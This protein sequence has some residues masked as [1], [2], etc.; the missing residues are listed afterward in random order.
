MRVPGSRA[1]F[2]TILILGPTVVPAVP[3]EAIELQLLASGLERPLGLV[4]AGDNTNRMFLVQQIGL[5]SII[6][7]GE[8]DPRPFLDISRQVSCCG[9]RGL[10]GLAFHPGY[11]SNGFFFAYYIDEEGDSVVSRFEVSGRSPD[12]ARAASEVEFLRFEQPTSGHKG[13]DI[14]FGS[15]GFLYIASGD[16]SDG[17]DPED[18]AQDLSSPL[19]KILRLDVD[20]GPGAVPSANPFVGDPQARDDIWALG[21]RNPWRIS[22]DRETG[23]FFVADVGQGRR[24]EVNFQSADSTGGEN[25]GWRRVEGSLCYEPPTGC[26]QDAFTPPVLEYGHDV[27]CAVTGGYRYRGKRAPTLR[28]EYVFGDYCAGTIWSAKPNRDGVWTSRILA[29]TGRPIVTF[30][31]DE[32]GELYLV[33]F[34]GEVN[35]LHS[36]EIFADGFESGDLAQWKREGAVD[37]TEPGLV[38]SGFA[39]AA[40][41]EAGGP[42]R[43][44]TRAPGRAESLEARVYLNGKGLDLGNGSTDVLIFGDGRG[45]HVRLAL[46]R[47]SKNRLRA[48]LRVRERSGAERRIGEVRF[49]RKKTVLLDV[50]WASSSSAMAADGVARLTKNGKTTAEADDLATGSRVV[51]AVELGFPSGAP[52]TS[53]GRLLMDGVSLTR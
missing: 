43:V 19:G 49:G 48:V 2:F 14:A 33:D 45:V 3:G 17:G 22:F 34:S 29:V 36:R 32:K 20:G 4:N 52:D 28:G 11:E 38:G 47:R 37:I 5:V 40:S 39:L 35:R 10:L 25:Y 30:G 18:N 9:G 41:T 15:D 27:G 13:G 21:L 46:E 51:T 7:N 12:R 53:S 50:E 26:D 16:G 6:R 8:L 1:V 24:E 23:D 44:R 42:A 31:E